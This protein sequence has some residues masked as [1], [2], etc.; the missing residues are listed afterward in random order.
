M[1][2]LALVEHW[3]V[4]H[5]AAGVV[6]LERDGTAASVADCVGDAHRLFAWASLSKMLVALALLVACEERAVDLDEPAGP[7][8]STVRHLLAHASGLSPDAP[9]PITAPERRRIY[10]NAGF[11]VLARH[12]AHRSGM[13]FVEYLHEGVLRPLGM[14]RTVL[15]LDASPASG[16]MGPL[17]DLLALGR[18][19]LVPVL[20]SAGTLAEATSVAYPGL[21]GVLPGF[22]RYDPC[23][24]GLGPEVKGA[25]VPHWTGAAN[26]PTTFGHFG[27]SGSFLWVDPEAGVACGALGDLAFGPWAAEAWPPLADAVIAQWGRGSAS[28]F[29]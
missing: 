22:G 10:S 5:S 19:L 4:P 21:A 7:P 24:W 1:R 27:R 12:L 6:C 25:K 20:V 17:A 9:V 26:G 13:T 14:T 23:D 3:P 28:T 8:G 15:P 29:A 16:V 18:E 2:A 11:E